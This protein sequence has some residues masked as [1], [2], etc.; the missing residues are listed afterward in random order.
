MNELRGSQNEA[1]ARLMSPRSIAIVGASTDKSK[2]AGQIIPMLQRTGFEGSIFPVNPRYSTLDDL[3]CYASLKEVPEP[4]DHA[5]LVVAKSRLGDIL[6][7]CAAVRVGSAS[8]YSAGFAET[9]A[10]GQ[11]AQRALL[12]L[13]DGMPF[14]GP[15][16]MGF[17]NLLERVFATTAPA[18]LRHTQPGDVALLSQSGGLAFASICYAAVE[19]G[20]KFTHVVNTGN[21]AGIDMGHLVEYVAAQPEVKVIL[22][23][24][25][26]EVVAAD[27]LRSLR[28]GRV[29]KPIVLLKL[30]RGV[31]GT[32]MA[33]SHTGSLA[34]DYRVLRDIMQQAGVM[35]V[36]DIDEVVAAATL[37][38]AGFTESH[39]S[40]VA[41]LSISGG[42]I[43]LL[44]DAMDRVKVT[45]AD[46]GRQTLD[47]LR[48]GLPDY[49][50]IHNPVDMTALGYE[51][52]E[53]HG[54]IIQILGHDSAVKV[55]T[56]I[57]TTMEDYRPVANAMVTAFSQSEGWKLA[58]VWNGGSYDGETREIFASAEI[59]VFSTA[60]SLATA[61][62]QLARVQAPE[63]I[64][65]G[66]SDRLPDEFHQ[67][68]TL[69]ES[70]SLSVL[71]GLGVPTA[72][73]RTC[74]PD[75][76][77]SIA[78][79]IGFPVVLKVDS[80]DTHISDRGAVV[81]NLSSSR[82]VTQA[83]NSFPAGTS[84]ETLLVMKQLKGTEFIA[85][86]FHHPAHG[87]L[88]MFGPG[89]QLVELVRDVRFLPLPVSRG[90]LE[91]ALTETVLGAALLEGARGMSGFSEFVDFLD[92]LSKGFLDD[93]RLV[94]AEI[95]PV[96]VGG[97]GAAAVDASVVYW[98]IDGSSD[99][100]V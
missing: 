21:T 100:R 14:L 96:I 64:S 95:N 70:A 52:P 34:G 78:E 73:W 43:T 28:T 80:S 2:L 77:G 82:G 61:L 24:I 36:D 57:L 93:P 65:G 6:T 1:I 12:E 32:A 35:C 58:V 31:T 29:D 42:N 10:D 46:L 66:S 75:Q 94:R 4:I 90:R 37:L 85:S 38:R 19:R 44:A 45:F 74:G 88:L 11:D 7:D 68:A 56:P 49:I 13:A 47:A 20:L 39:T 98:S 3:T 69:S 23:V 86:V 97:H 41:A 25:E 81:L 40:G 27:V 17:A 76:A 84:T 72:S 9:G 92:C 63:A 26:S 91:S 16:C 87:P 54:D 53:L 99:F 15:N 18:L 62:S 48:E 22:L 8:I 79:A 59:P 51:R 89:G 67:F 55:I 30:G 50:S 33:A 71:D 83:V 60:S 5:V